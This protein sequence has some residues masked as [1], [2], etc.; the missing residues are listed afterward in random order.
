MRSATSRV[1][2]R[3]VQT[4]NRGVGKQVMIALVFHIGH[5]WV[6]TLVLCIPPSGFRDV[7]AN[8]TKPGSFLVAI[9]TKKCKP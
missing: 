4:P 3:K 7:R 9:A 6:P 8:R 2:I 1:S 5:T